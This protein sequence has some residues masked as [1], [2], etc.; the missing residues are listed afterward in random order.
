[1][2]FIDISYF[3]SDLIRDNQELRDRLTYFQTELEKKNKENFDLEK[4]NRNLRVSFST[5]I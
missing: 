3:N 4:T 1:M 5:R 2:D